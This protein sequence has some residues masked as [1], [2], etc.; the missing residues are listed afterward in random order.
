MVGHRP[1]KTF[2]VPCHGSRSIHTNKSNQIFNKQSNTLKAVSKPDCT[3]PI[4]LVAPYQ[5]I[6]S[7]YT[8]DLCLNSTDL[9]LI[10]IQMTKSADRFNLS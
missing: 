4:Y 7:G 8:T 10:T 1:A 5:L 6:Y 3:L 2:A 9:L